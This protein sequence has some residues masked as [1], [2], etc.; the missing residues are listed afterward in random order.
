MALLE[1]L[2]EAQRRREPELAAETPS[3]QEGWKDRT[4]A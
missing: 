1:A 2:A 3:I 4:N